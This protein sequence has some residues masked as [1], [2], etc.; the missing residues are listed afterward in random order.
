MGCVYICVYMY[1]H[2]CVDVCAVCPYVCVHTQRLWQI[3]ALLPGLRVWPLS[4]APGITSQGPSFL[5]VS[6]LR[7]FQTIQVVHT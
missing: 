5:L 6:W 1:L 4:L 3:A 2:V 7:G